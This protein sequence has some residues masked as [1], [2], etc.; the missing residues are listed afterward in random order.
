[1][2][3]RPQYIE[4]MVPEEWYHPEWIAEDC[5]RMSSRETTVVPDRPLGWPGNVWMGVTVE[6]QEALARCERLLRC[7]ARMRFLSCEP[8]LG[9]IICSNFGGIHWIIIGC[10]QLP[11][12]RPGRRCELFWVRDLVARARAAHVAVFIKQLEIAGRVS[13]DPA[14]W[15]EDLRVQEFPT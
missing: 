1:M 10:E 6:N 5:R 2:T 4:A 14:E 7:P 9:P 3:K 11:G 12:H 15:P 8:L 13:A